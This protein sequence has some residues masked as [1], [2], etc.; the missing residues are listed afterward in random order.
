MPPLGVVTISCAS[1][2]V[3]FVSQRADGPDS[4]LVRLDRPC[5][6]KANPVGESGQGRK[7]TRQSFKVTLIG[8]AAVAWP[9][10]ARAQ[11]PGKIPKIGFFF[12]G[13]E[14]VAP[15]RIYTSSVAGA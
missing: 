5:R 4:R 14:T 12:P 7:V 1:D 15:T 3:S 11:Q 13:T 10:G 6:P 2:F 8:G 9:L